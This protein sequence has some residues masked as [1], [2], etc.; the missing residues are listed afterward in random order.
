MVAPGT[1]ETSKIAKKA[2]I[3]VLDIVLAVEESAAATTAVKRLSTATV[4][5]S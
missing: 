2:I 4:A 5:I 3:T 1:S